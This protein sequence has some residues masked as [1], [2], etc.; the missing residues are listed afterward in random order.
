MDIL[1][2]VTFWKFTS[3]LHYD[4]L[5]SL[6][7][8]PEIL[9]KI[10]Q[11]THLAPYKEDLFTVLSE[12]YNNA[13]DHGILKL[14]SKLKNGSNGFTSFYKKREKL[15][16]NLKEGRITIEVSHQPEYDGGRLTF[17]VTDSG[18]GFDMNTIKRDSQKDSEV[19]YHGRGMPLINEICDSVNY[20]EKGNSI[21]VRYAWTNT[22]PSCLSRE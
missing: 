19:R 16:S 2:A 5:R 21:K 4:V 6:N 12:L 1:I 15:L 3:T 22:K 17:I 8:V 18:D 9:N 20:S 11:F 13:L 10:L 7:P 14:D